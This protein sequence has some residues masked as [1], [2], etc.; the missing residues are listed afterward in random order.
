EILP[1]VARVE[2]CGA[3]GDLD[4]ETARVPCEQGQCSMCGVQVSEQTRPEQTHLGIELGL[5]ERC[6]PLDVGF[7]PDVVDEDVETTVVGFD[8]AD[9]LG[10][11]GRI[12]VITD[13]G[14]GLAAFVGDE[15]GGVFDR[16]C[17]SVVGGTPVGRSAGAVDVGAGACEVTGD[18]AAGSSGGPG[19]EG[20]PA[21]QSSSG[22]R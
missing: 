20:D 10:D 14:F 12:E 18:G 19:D 5:P 21:A 9:H 4:M 3:V 13:V 6:A 15:G 16:L 7:S 17:A 8:L 11:L 2:L 22:D 1:V